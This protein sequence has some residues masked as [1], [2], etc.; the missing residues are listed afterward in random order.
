MVH[1]YNTSP[2]EVYSKLVEKIDPKAY[3][4]SNRTGAGSSVS[5]IRILFSRARKVITTLD[6]LESRIS[7]L[8]KEIIQADKESAKKLG[9]EAVRKFNGLEHDSTVTESR[10]RII[11]LEED[12]TRFSCLS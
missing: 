7:A 5:A 12:R 1:N 9:T 3:N 8:Q 6:G 11:M 10:L 2:A 4:S